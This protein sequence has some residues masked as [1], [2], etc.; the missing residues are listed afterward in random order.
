L[1]LLKPAIAPRHPANNATLVMPDGNMARDTA[2][3]LGL[4]DVSMSHNG[5]QIVMQRS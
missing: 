5:L 4:V 3:D 2:N 1:R